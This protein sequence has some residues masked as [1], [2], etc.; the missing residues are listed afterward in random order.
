MPDSIP[1]DIKLER[2]QQIIDLQNKIANDINT[3]L[4]GSTQS[5][6]V[7]GHSKRSNKSFS[8]RTDTNKTTVIKSDVPLSVG[9]I[10]NVEITQATSATLI[11]KLV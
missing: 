9:Q 3:G 2:L 7:E 5:V 11:G 10:V 6:L 1:Y 8:G 4:I